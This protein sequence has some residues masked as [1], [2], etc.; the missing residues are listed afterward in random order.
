MKSILGH[1]DKVS[2]IENFS[3]IIEW[4]M[5]TQSKIDTDEVKDKNALVMR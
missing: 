5:T 2:L 1:K 3:M 4:L